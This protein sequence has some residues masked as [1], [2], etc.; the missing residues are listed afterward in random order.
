MNENKV[1]ITVINPKA[2]SLGR[3]YGQFDSLSHEWADGIIAV[4]FRTY[5]TSS[6]SIVWML[7]EMDTR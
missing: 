1:H 6:V 5:A 4:T 7:P 2:L 3:L